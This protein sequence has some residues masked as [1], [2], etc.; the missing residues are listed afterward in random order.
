MRLLARCLLV[1]AVLAAANARSANAAQAVRSFRVKVDE[2]TSRGRLSG[3]LDVSIPR[4]FEQEKR[5]TS[6]ADA[7]SFT[8]SDGQG[9]LGH[10]S[11]S[12]RAE[13]TT[14]S[15][16]RQIQAALPSIRAVVTLGHGRRPHGDW[17]LDQLKPKSGKVDLYGIAPIRV[18]AQ[19]FVQVRPI[20]W[21]LDSCSEASVRKGLMATTAEHILREGK[22]NVRLAGRRAR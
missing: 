12:V 17:Q 15:I 1:L 10:M 9:C 3:W 6:K 21:F 5:S 14:E 7:P 2:H 4:S 20:V 8:F 19:L 16:S 11:L 13:T 18:A 22:L